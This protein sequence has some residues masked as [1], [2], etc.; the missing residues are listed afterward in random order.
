MIP[1]QLLFYF[2]IVSPLLIEKNLEEKTH[3]ALMPCWVPADHGNRGMS[4]QVTEEASWHS[5]L[6]DCLTDYT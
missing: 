3:I 5:P 2:K 4:V 6:A 1:P